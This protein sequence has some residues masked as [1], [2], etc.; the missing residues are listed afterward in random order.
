MI[1]RNKVKYLGIALFLSLI[2]LPAHAY[3]GPGSSIGILIVILTVI[4]AFFSS[5]ILKSI[6]FIKNLL[7]KTRKKSSKNKETKSQ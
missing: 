2:Q 4:L 5:V 3:A 1:I 7:N 6:N